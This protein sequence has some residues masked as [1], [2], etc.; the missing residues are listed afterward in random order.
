MTGPLAEVDVAILLPFACGALV[1]MA[2]VVVLSGFLP[3]RARP[4]TG[5]QRL[6]TMAVCTAVA[7]TAFLILALCLTVPLL[8]TAVAVIAAGFAVLAG[9]FLIQPIPARVRE[10]GLALPAILTLVAIA[11]V[12]LPRPF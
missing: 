1:A 7:A 5:A 6:H 4:A 9:P 11:V 10:S 3:I 2:S 12:M 8:P